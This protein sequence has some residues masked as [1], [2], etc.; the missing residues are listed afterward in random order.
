MAL[1]LES[2]AKL[3]DTKLNPVITK[4]DSIEKSVKSQDERIT[5]L[6]ARMTQQE[7]GSQPP[8]AQ[9]SADSSRGSRFM[10][11]FVEIKGFCE[12]KDRREK[13]ITRSQAEDLV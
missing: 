5:S 9:A 6:E 10:P 7:Q 8:T 3:L 4:V 2:M 11:S 13:G 1:T 12:W